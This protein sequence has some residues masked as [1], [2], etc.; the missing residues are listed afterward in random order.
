MTINF[1]GRHFAF[2]ECDTMDKTEAEVIALA[3]KTGE[4]QY[5]LNG[6]T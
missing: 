2:R 5:E 1:K 4:L 3:D 6:H